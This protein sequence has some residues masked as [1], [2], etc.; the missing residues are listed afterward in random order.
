MKPSVAVIGVVLGLAA[1]TAFGQ[2]PAGR[3]IRFNGRTLT[4]VQMER[5]EVL[6]RYYRVRIPDNDYWY[7]NRSGA[8]GFW[9]GPAIAALP[10]G[11]GLG[12][13]MPPDCSAGGTGVFVNGRELHP[14]DVLALM[15][16]L[17]PV[18]RGRYWLNGDGSYGIE[19]G[20]MLGN[21]FAISR[22]SRG[23]HR[24]YEPGELSGLFG[25]SAGYCT[26]SG[27]AYTGR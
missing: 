14:L 27:C 18:Y 15:S 22:Q 2:E 1:M 13:P 16:L 8:A 12:G 26:N 5:L 25:N 10:P 11:L 21:L 19:R 17:G 9:H 3:R 7:D 23:P 20:P 4:P 6:E 24:V